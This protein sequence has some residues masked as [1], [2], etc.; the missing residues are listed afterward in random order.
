MRNLIVSLFLLLP[1]TATAS[2]SENIV[3]LLD[4]SGSMSAR[5]R[6]VRVSRMEGAQKALIAIADQLPP[7]TN[8]GI[9]TFKGWAYPLQA[10]DKEALVTAI[11]NTY[12]TGGT[13]LGRFMKDAGD[14]LLTARQ[15]NK[16]IGNYRLLVVTDGEAED[17]AKLDTNMYDIVGRGIILDTIGV[18]MNSAHSLKK[19]SKKYM[20]ADDPDSLKSAVASALA[21]VGKTKGD[22]GTGNFEMLS[23]LDEGSA[24][25]IISGL[26]EQFNQPVGEQPPVKV[27]DENGNVSYIPVAAAAKP[28][29]YTGVWVFLGLL[30]FIVVGGVI[31][32]ILSRSN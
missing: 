18:D 11:N 26:T 10:V 13:P 9:L 14:A 29:S 31:V 6:K 27:V 22:D 8:I 5:M 23:G 4:T 32:L 25:A 21:E 7:N 28:Q 16:G 30:A 3:I 2:A 15:K 20:S 19:A 12:A 1:A 24:K 17:Q